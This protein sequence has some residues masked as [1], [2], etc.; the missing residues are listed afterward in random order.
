VTATGER[1][2]VMDDQ[3]RILIIDDDRGM[4]ETL[5]LILR[6]KGSSVETASSGKAGIEHAQRGPF[7]VVLL[8]IKLPDAQGVDLLEPLLDLHPEAGVIVI[9]GH[10]SVKTAVRALNAGAAAY[11]TKPL[12]M[13]E[14]LAIIDRELETQ[15][16]RLEKQRAERALRESNAEYQLLAENVA[17]VIYKL[18][19]ASGRY[20]YISP[21]VE[22]V[23]GYAP[24][25]L[26]ALGPQDVLT[27]ESF[28]RQSRGLE[29]ALVIGRELSA[30]MELE[31]VHNDGRTVPVEVRAKLILDEGGDPTEI[32]GVARDVAERKE[33]E[34]RLRRQER[35]AALGQMAS[36]IAH[37]FRNRLN[38]IILYAD[39]A[40]RE[41]GISPRLA[42]NFETVLEEAQGMANLV[43]QILDFTSQS[44]LDRRPLDLGDLLEL[45]A[46]R[47]RRALPPGVRLSIS[48]DPGTYLVLA[49]R[50]R[51]SQAVKNLASN[52]LDAMVDGGELRLD[53]S[54]V[55]PP[56]KAVAAAEGSVAK[57]GGWICLSVSDTGTGMTEEVLAHVFEPFFTTKDVGGGTGLGL[58]QLHGIVRQ[59]GG[60]IDVDSA[61]GRGTTMRIYLPAHQEEEGGE[62]PDEPRRPRQEKR[63]TVLLV[64]ADDDLRAAGSRMLKS[65][66]YTVVTA[67]D[68][69][70]AL[71]ICQSARWGNE[72]RDIDVVIAGDDKPRTGEALVERLRRGRSN[73]KVI[74][75]RSHCEQGGRADCDAGFPDLVAKPFDADLLARAVRRVLEGGLE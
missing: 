7:D 10:A 12:D 8:D 61:P 15:R 56:T 74:L 24:E 28:A 16:L 18:D 26:L 49:D 29:E 57:T 75:T 11:V 14:V 5:A 65:M 46:E 33:M 39:M 27:P 21:S 22:R 17:D 36:G 23:L 37:D 41:G 4:R 6:R 44:M 2:D 42:G 3:A 71:A 43:Q 1:E 58:S 32:Q 38:P 50:G 35:L 9:T 54:R 64:E 68:E 13:D 53:L 45:E 52:A 69:R 48:H 60:F 51:I 66:G 19:L 70:E 67:A 73:L 47:M 20:T 55:D 30:P 59:H 40:L 63:A 25:E 34:G 72:Q 31:A 62:E